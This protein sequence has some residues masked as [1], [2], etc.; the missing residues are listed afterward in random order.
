MSTGESLIVSLLT[1]IAWL[2]YQIV[3][4]LSYLTGKRIK[5]S[6]FNRQVQGVQF[7]SKSKAKSKPK[8]DEGPIEK[9]PN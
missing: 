8:L 3:K 6:I 7:K 9:L 2:L 1:V 5:M 4:Q